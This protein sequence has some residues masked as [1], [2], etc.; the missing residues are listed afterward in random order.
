MENNEAE[1]LISSIMFLASTHLIIESDRL[2]DVFLTSVRLFW[3]GEGIR[4]S[5]EN[6]TEGDTF[7][8]EYSVLEE[9]C[10]MESHEYWARF[11]L[12]GSQAL[13]HLLKFRH[14]V[15]TVFQHCLPPT[16]CGGQF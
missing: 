12:T 4:F 13:T 6:N 2:E 5:P 14:G 16:S 8:D 9:L 11:Y 10:G 7:F 15:E 1:S 3:G